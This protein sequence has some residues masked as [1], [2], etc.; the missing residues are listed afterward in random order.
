MKKLLP[1]ACFILILSACNNGDQD[2]S[3][4]K[5]AVPGDETESIASMP[6]KKLALD[7]WTYIEI[8]SNKAMW[9]EFDEPEWLRYFGLAAGDMNDDGLADII[10]GRNIYYNPGGDLSSN[11]KKEDLG[12]NVDA[13]L[14]MTR[15]TDGP[16]II[17]EALPDVYAFYRDQD[18]GEL[19]KRLVAQVPP[20]GHHNGQGYRTA[21]LRGGMFD[22]I[23]L[24]SQGGLYVIEPM[25]Y[26]LEYDENGEEY[27]VGDEDNAW[28]VTLVAQDASDEGF[29]VADMD[30]DNDLDIVSGYRVPGKDA[31]VPTVVV[32]WENPAEN[33]FIDTLWARHEVGN[34]QFA[35]D[36]V[37]AADLNGDGLTDVVVA[38]ERYPGLEPDASLYVYFQ[39]S[40]GSFKR[41]TIVTQFSMNNL[42]VAD[43]DQDGDLDLTTAEHKGEALTLQIWENDGEGKFNKLVIDTGKESH[44]GARTVD[45]DGDGDLDIISIGWDQHK[46][47][48]LWRNDA[49]KGM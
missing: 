6:A 19:T 42:D 22:D 44:L 26:G 33:G 27:L 20:T 21:S 8:D 18:S 4:F 29:A 15:V 37:E 11:W 17:A 10:T 32:W 16:T 31:E 43:L 36:R 40:G 41:A 9:G 23:I 45:I 46:Y 2:K 25:D 35:T 3:D 30:G 38:E 7:Q 39:Q 48:H 28:P 34:T 5:V 1:F 14:F 13:N 47:V 49:I 12:L 24:A